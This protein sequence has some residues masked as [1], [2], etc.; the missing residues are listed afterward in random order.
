MIL[1]KNRRG[2]AGWASVGCNAKRMGSTSMHTLLRQP[3]WKNQQQIFPD[4]THTSV[5]EQ[6]GAGVRSRKMTRSRIARPY[7]FLP[8]LEQL[9]HRV[10]MYR[11][12]VCTQV[13]QSSKL[14]DSWCDRRNQKSACMCLTSRMQCMCEC[15]NGGYLYRRL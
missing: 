3:A 1:E 4:L 2:Q 9:I 14:A 8:A 13:N 7:L 10:G 11:Y 15:V 5:S 6:G 12:T